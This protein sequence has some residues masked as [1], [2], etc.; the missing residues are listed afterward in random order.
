MIL[1]KLIGKRICTV[2]L[3]FSL[4]QTVFSGNENDNRLQPRLVVGIVVDQMRFDY[5]YRFYD[6]YTE[7]GFKL[8]MKEGMNFTYA[9]YNYIPTYT[10]PGHSAIYTGT[11]PYCNGIISNDWYDKNLKKRIYCVKD[12]SVQTVGANDNS[13]QM[14]P[15]N[16][17]ATT[18]TDQLRMSNN[19]HSR[20]FSISI[21]DR[22]AILP[23]G[24]MA[25]AAY[26][27]DGKNGKFVSSTYYMNELPSWVNQFNDEMIPSLLMKSNWNLETG[28]NYETSF[29]DQ[30]PGEEDIFKEGK[31]TFPHEFALK[32]DSIKREIIKSTPFGNELLADFFTR[33]LRNEKPGQGKYCDFI[34]IS[35]SSTDYVGHAYG[36]N[37]VEIMDTYIKLDKQIA[38]IIDSLN[39][40]VGKGNYLLFLTADHGVKPNNAYLESERVRSGSLITQD[41]EK[42]LKAY[43]KIQFKTPQIVETI[44]DN[45]I[46][47]DHNV[48]DS[49]NLSES[50][51]DEK[52]IGYIRAN[53]SYIGQIMTKE[54][55]STKTPSRSM[56]SFL[57]NGF[58]INR[59]GDLAFEHIQNYITDGGKEGTSHESSFNYD[60]H[61]PLLF[62]GWHIKPGESNTEVFIEDIAA[63][64]CNL[65]HIQEPDACI[66][67]PI[68]K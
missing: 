59:S 10:G 15:K 23:G 63:T 35:F 1:Y 24:H 56:N 18:M 65:I 48:L 26:W 7:N 2:V 30:G 4:F 13:G 52:L 45:Q 5:L 25:N 8:L 17:A 9:Q 3:L 29:P 38:N 64:I 55:L 54:A 31:T 21:K 6:Q 28:I 57:I 27:Y 40:V 47:L 42:Q 58:N 61:V 67:I 33:L 62:Y 12:A 44:Q 60:T 50:M 11:T 32:N 43:C 53:I 20:V 34:A 37:S 22:A 68:I 16:L 39:R 14:S 49:L 46:Y 66:G 36:P 51:V 41:L 19:N